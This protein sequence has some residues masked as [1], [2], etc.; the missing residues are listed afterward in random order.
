[1]AGERPRISKVLDAVSDDPSRRS[2]HCEAPSGHAEARVDSLA[3]LS[4]PTPMWAATSGRGSRFQE[5]RRVPA[6]GARRVVALS[7]APSRSQ[8]IQARV[9]VALLAALVALGAVW[10]GVSFEDLDRLWKDILARPGGPMTFRFI[11]QPAMAAIAALRDGVNDA[12][13]GRRPYLWAIMRGVRSVEGRRGR[14]WEGIVSTA[15]IF[16]FLAS[17]W[18]PSTNGWSS[19]RSTRSRRR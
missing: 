10:Y 14:L 1:M 12:R 7:D 16:Q 15:R 13:L 19:R 2:A 11:L 8:I 5:L 6:R 17:S 18:T 3:R 9:A 4:S